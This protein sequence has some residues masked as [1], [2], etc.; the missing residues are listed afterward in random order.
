M[1]AFRIGKAMTTQVLD[2]QRTVPGRPGGKIRS[3]TWYSLAGI[4]LFF[5]YLRLSSTYAENSDMANI[6]LMGADLLHGNLLLHGWHMSDVSFYPTELVQYALLESVLG[7]SM[8]TAHVAAAL[9]YTLVVLLT[10]LLARGT[11]HGPEAV[12]RT[13]LAGGIMIAPQLSAGVYAVDLAVG[14]IGTSVPLLL[15]WLSIDRGGRRWPV[16][17]LSA[18]LLAWVLVADPLVE[19]VGI[20]PL[21]LVAGLSFTVRLAR[22][23][24]RWFDAG[25]AG[26]ALIGY[27]LALAAQAVLR[28]LGGYVVSPVPVQLRTLAGLPGAAPALWRVLDLFGADFRGMRPG[29]P[30]LLALAHLASVALVVAA[31]GRA[32]GPRC[33]ATLVD[34]V[35]AVG[36]TAN[37]VLY[38]GTLTSTQGAHEI[39]VV[40]PYAA[41]LA[42]RVLAPALTA[43]A[44]RAGRAPSPRV[45]RHDGV[46]AA[47]VSVPAA[48][49]LLV[50]AGYLAGLGY[51]LTFP[52]APPANSALASW[53]LAH[54][55][56]SG[57]AGYWQSSS[58]TV[59]SGG[60]V[61]VRAVTGA[62]APYQ[63]MTDTRWYDP[64]RNTASFLILQQL[65]RSGLARLEA[66]FGPASQV[67]QVDGYTVLTWPRNL[68][69]G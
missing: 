15:C 68:L 63:W 66:R 64:V 36:I 57:L 67:Y 37:L 40:L 16:P 9:T 26:A 49:G 33:G 44:R 3:A 58:I 50:L 6:L 10:V 45:Q 48:A 46:P 18:V 59:D 24:P 27:A 23:Q 42:G 32:C 7:L 38:L 65:P 34:R 5:C 31:L 56:R 8:T 55:L 4:V 1:L 13:L 62:L 54:G 19:V 61:T 41:A 14:H 20:A 28:A 53:L 30:L 17:L 21:A 43:R 47:R 22:G 39:A 25:L 29:V 35:L 12:A 11:A 51:E 2:L 52:S 69:R 60:R